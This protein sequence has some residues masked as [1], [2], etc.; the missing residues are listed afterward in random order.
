MYNT[1]APCAKPVHSLYQPH[2]VFPVE[3][4]F[5]RH[6][7]NRCK[8]YNCGTPVALCST[9]GDK[10]FHCGRQ[11]QRRWFVGF[12]GTWPSTASVYWA[13]WVQNSRLRHIPEYHLVPLATK[14]LW[15]WATLWHAQQSIWK[16]F[17]E[18]HQK[19]VPSLAN[20]RALG[21]RWEWSAFAF[22][23][24]SFRH[25]HA[26]CSAVFAVIL[27]LLETVCPVLD[28]ICASAHPTVVG[29]LDHTA[30]LIITYFSS[31]TKIRSWLRYRPLESAPLWE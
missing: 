23:Y 12:D 28:N 3:G 27:L 8:K 29:F 10:S 22:F 16:H 18:Q 14:C 31:T 30:Y 21:R 9:N 19:S 4:L 24:L 7:R 5:G 1:N 6:P 17:V 20:L 15:V 11:W 26:M 25:Q 13:F 2:D